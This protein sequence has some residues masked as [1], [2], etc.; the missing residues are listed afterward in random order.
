[1]TDKTA[2]EE[3]I[4][5]EELV[6]RFDLNGAG[7]CV[8]DFC[9]SD[10]KLYNGSNQ[11]GSTATTDVIT[12]GDVTFAGLDSDTD[13]IING[14]TTFT[15]KATIAS[16]AAFTAGDS[17]KVSINNFGSASTAGAITGGDV[18]WEDGEAP[19]AQVEWIDTA[20]TSIDGNTFSFSN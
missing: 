10:V 9:I 8:G 19:T 6:L 4:N 5:L 13:A 15:V 18:D 12:S 17:L 1:M 20:L 2:G 16:G 11:V 7:A 14:A 3:S